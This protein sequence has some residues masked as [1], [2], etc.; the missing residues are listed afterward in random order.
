LKNRKRKN[1]TTPITNN[2]LHIV[3]PRSRLAVIDSPRYGQSNAMSLTNN[4]ADAV[5]RDVLPDPLIAAGAVPGKPDEK[6]PADQVFFRHES[7]VTAVVAVVAVVAHDE[8][9]PRRDHDLRRGTV[10]RAGRQENIVFHTVQPLARAGRLVLHLAVLLNGVRRDFLLRHQ[11]AV[12]VD[13]LALVNDPIARK[14]DDAF[15]VIDRFVAR[16]AKHHHVAAL[17]LADIDDLLVY[18]RQPY[19]VGKFI[20]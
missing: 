17:G 13:L 9:V 1:A 11:L 8:V 14:A 5:N 3:I 18:H 7:P 19:A 16:K 4:I 6:G 2:P 10:I 12:N 20:H 15:D